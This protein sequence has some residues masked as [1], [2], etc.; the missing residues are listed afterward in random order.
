MVTWLPWWKPANEGLSYTPH[1]LGL[2][3]LSYSHQIPEIHNKALIL[4]REF[5]QPTNNLHR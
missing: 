3:P 2:L 1:I 5:T 4:N